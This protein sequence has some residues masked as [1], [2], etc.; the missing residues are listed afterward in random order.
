MSSHVGRL[1]LDDLISPKQVDYLLDSDAFINL[2]EGSIRA[3]KSMSG[4][5][6]W[7][8]HVESAPKKGDLIVTGKTADTVAR[9]VF[10]PLRERAVFGDIAKSIQYTRGAPTAKILGRTIEIV[11]FNNSASEERLRGLTACG[12][13]VDEWTLMGEEFHQQL[14]GRCSV[15]GA[16]IFGNTNPDNPRHWL[17]LILN[18][19]ADNARK[20]EPVDIKTWHFTIDDNPSLSEKVKERWRRMFTGLWYKRMILGQWVMAEGAIF[21]SW[22]EDR[23]VVKDLPTITKWISL[24]VDYGTTNPFAGLVLG[25]GADHKLYLTHEWR[26]DSKKKQS[27]LSDAH[28]STR[29]REWVKSIGVTPQWWCVDPSAASFRE[30]LRGDG[31]TTFPANNSVI[32]GIRLMDSLLTLDMLRVHESCEGLRAEIPGYVWDPE[33]TEK[34][35]DEP[36]KLDDHSCDA[37]RYAIKTPEVTWRPLVKGGLELAA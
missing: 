27:K 2:A 9:N 8:K 29:L 18:D 4:L 26:W 30:Q 32:D 19:A 31:Q 15:N 37:A 1:N 24:G 10:N 20:G 11:T 12:A 25:V 28:Y 3:G 33:K 13:F 23:H 6:R 5:L 36:I 34:G 14:V 22:D 16:Q 7:L 17:K 35:L 21:E